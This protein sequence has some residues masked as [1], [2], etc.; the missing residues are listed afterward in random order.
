MI[1]FNYPRTGVTVSTYH[2]CL[3]TDIS[4]N[5]DSLDSVARQLFDRFYEHAARMEDVIRRLRGMRPL[6]LD[7]VAL[8]VDVSDP[9]PEPRIPTA[10]RAGCRSR[11]RR[12][13]RSRPGARR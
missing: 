8:P 4:T 3:N 1:S 6:D 2:V 5:L 13:M 7:V 12:P 9:E 10:R 11:G